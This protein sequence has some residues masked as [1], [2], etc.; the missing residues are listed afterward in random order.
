[1]NYICIKIDSGKPSKMPQLFR[2]TYFVH[3]G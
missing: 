2:D 1:L 3:G